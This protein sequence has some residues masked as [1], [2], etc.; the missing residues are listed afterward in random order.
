M[1]INK[2]LLLLI[3]LFTFSHPLISADKDPDTR[4]TDFWVTYL[5]NYHNNY[6]SN[7]PRLKF[8][9]SLYIFIGATEPTSGTIEYWDKSEQ[10]HE[11]NFT[12]TNPDELYMFRVSWWDYEIKGS[13]HNLGD[14]EIPIKQSFHIT[15]ESDVTIYA[16]NQAQMS[17]DAFNVMP[18]D[19]LGK[20]Y[21]VMSY[22]NSRPYS[23]LSSMTPSQFAIVATEDGTHVRI[24]P[25]APTHKKASSKVQE[26][27][28]N[29][30]ESY[31]VEAYRN[32]YSSAQLDLTGSYV[33]TSKPV[34]VFSGHTRASVPVKDSWSG[35]SRDCLMEQ[36]MPVESWGNNV[37]LFPFKS[38]SNQSSEENDLYRIL[39]A[40]DGTEI[41]IDDIFITSLDKGEFHEGNLTR[42]HS[43]KSNKP[44]MVCQYKKSSKGSGNTTKVSDPFMMY[45][46]QTENF[47]I[48][49]RFI[50]IQSHEYDTTFKNYYPVYSEHYITVISKIS[51]I[52]TIRLDNKPITGEKSYNIGNTGWAYIHIDVS[53]GVH[54]IESPS[55]FGLYIYGYGEANSYGYFGGVSV[56]YFDFLPPDITHK[57]DC[58]EFEGIIA[59][60]SLN[61][62]YIDKVEAT[63]TNNVN[64]DFNGFTSGDKIVNF[65]ASL[66]NRNMDG[67]FTIVATDSATHET[68]EN[69]EIPGYTLSFTNTEDNGSG[70]EYNDI[71]RVRNQFCF[72]L[73]I[74]NHGKFTQIINQSDFVQGGDD[75]TIDTPMPLDI[76]PGQSEEIKICITPLDGGEYSD[77]LKLISDCD[78]SLITINIFAQDDENDPEFSMNQDPCN[79]YVELTI[80]DSTR[81]DFGIEKIEVTDTTNCAIFDFEFGIFESHMKVEVEDPYQDA[82]VSIIVTDSVGHETVIDHAIPGYTIVFPELQEDAYT[83]ISIVDYEGQ[84]IG[85]RYCY[86]LKIENYGSF[87][88]V[89]EDARMAENIFFSV[90]QAELPIEIQPGDFELLNVCFK[91]LNSN[92]EM[93]RDSLSIVFNCLTKIVPLEGFGLPFERTSETKCDIGV[94]MTT[95][96]VPETVLL[97]D[98]KPNPAT[99]QVIIDM[100]I[101]GSADVKVDIFDLSG[102]HVK[103]VLNQYMKAGYYTLTVDVSDLRQGMYVYRLFYGRDVKTSTLI[104][105]R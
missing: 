97:Q 44:I 28:L 18:T 90:P 59:D 31:L 95:S 102:N 69:Y 86:E 23:S 75:F 101:P 80:T 56:K 5:P 88:I 94:R 14:S 98:G 67:S 11:E 33:E 53:Q 81:L 29:Q 42:A 45:I 100:G 37:F 62:S 27:T 43:V 41:K 49:Y 91:P 79:R 74:K 61:D 71:C 16:H 60:T 8:G 4:G 58:F 105:A 21:M 96:K 89:F 7:K 46:P 51:A 35:G 99:E 17:S 26:F 40:F 64:V 50:N 85:G 68:T 93:Y 92:Q 39:A 55:Q 25:K 103:S 65:K 1:K 76:E 63:N 10:R 3:V 47:D 2:I 70:M 72:Y 104:I 66:V 38:G 24:E 32:E 15:S 9:D 48:F 22:N 19:A 36:M 12:I 20:K 83:S 6:D 13:V 84:E 54:T 30:G 78:E 34:A 73:T 52:P 82:F 87:P 57:E 77:I